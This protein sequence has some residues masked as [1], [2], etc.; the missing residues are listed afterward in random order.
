MSDGISQF[1]TLLTWQ[2]AIGEE[3]KADA[4]CRGM[5]D[6]SYDLFFDKWTGNGKSVCAGCRVATS[7]RWYAEEFEEAVGWRSGVWGGLSAPE[8]EKARP[9]RVTGDD[10]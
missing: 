3:W 7:C 2:A 6:T 10:E 9:L 8:R 1:V 5:S 4:A